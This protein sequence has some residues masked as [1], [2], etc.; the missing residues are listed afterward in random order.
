MVK[1]ALIGGGG[2][3]A[4]LFVQA[5]LTRASKI[6]LSEIALMDTDGAQL[7]IF[8]TIAREI[9]RQQASAVTIS[10]TTDA[11]VAITGADF[12]VTT[13][14]PGGIA[15]RIADE[16]IA[17]DLGVLGQETTG[18][19]GFAMA[20]RSIPIILDYARLIQELAPNAWLLNFTNPAGLVTQA[21]HNAGFSQAVGICDSANG[22]QH[23]V[24]H[25]LGISSRQVDAE[26]F[27]LNHLSFSPRVLVDG[28]DVLPRALA[29]DRFLDSSAQRVFER[30]LVRRHG[31]WLNEYLYYFYYAEKAVAALQAGP[32]RGEEIGLLNAELQ[33]QLAEIDLTADPAAGLA[34]YFAYEQRRS[35][36]YMRSAR[37][38]TAIEEAPVAPDGEGYAG[39]ALDII[40]ALTGGRALR[41]G[42]N[43]PNQGAIAALRDD[44]IVEVACTIDADG[45][46]P[47]AVGNLPEQQS[48]LIQSVK[49][50][51]RLTV[52]AIA[53]RDRVLAI[54]ALAAHPLVL[55]YSRAT[56]LVDQ[57]LAAHADFTGDWS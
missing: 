15:G 51:E 27:G 53:A 9:V 7:E 38:T 28:V 29:D 13:I 17:L 18:A 10:T 32:S 45:I 50:Y 33:G 48:Y 55:S 11:R 39:V 40:E 41:T 25:W 35:G 21:L 34:A 42:L 37:Q 3:R 49:H 24:A 1:L 46:R 54:E 22:A 36:S 6:G 31:V 5:A 20:L 57:Y 30:S 47:V 26:L 8:G 14:R 4:P 19:G 56:P 23:A 52:A 16:R 43:V 12:V 2:V 44:D